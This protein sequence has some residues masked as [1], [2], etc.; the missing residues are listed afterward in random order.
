MSRPFFLHPRATL[1]SIAWLTFTLGCSAQPAAH[2]QYAH[3]AM[4]PSE[5]GEAL[6]T[7][8]VASAEPTATDAR[9]I[10]GP[11]LVYQATLEL[12]VFELP[13]AQEA[14]IERARALGGVLHRQVDDRLMLQIPA[15]RFVAFL[16][17]VG[18]VGEVLHREVAAA[19]VGEE[20]RDLDVRIQNLEAMRARIESFL[21]A[22]HDVR[23]ALEVQHELERVTTE[24]ERLRGRQQFLAHRIALSSVTIVFHLRHRPAEIAQPEVFRLPFAWLDQLGLGGLLEVGR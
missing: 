11:L 12:A 14:L 7:A 17:S 5:G 21:A 19:D 24:L 9:D 13:A 15:E 20:F 16:A 18:E 8:S 6:A 4:A 3:L 23:D 1:V 2:P 10:A 22:A